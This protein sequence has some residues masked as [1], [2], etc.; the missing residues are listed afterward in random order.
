MLRDLYN[1]P[2]AQNRSISFIM[3]VE[4]WYSS[5]AVTLQPGSEQ[6]PV[7]KIPSEIYGER[8]FCQKSCN[9]GMY[10]KYMILCLYFTYDEFKVFLKFIGKKYRRFYFPGPFA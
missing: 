6:D 8:A 10:M 3:S 7:F 4:E 9:K 5:I 2:A 1:P